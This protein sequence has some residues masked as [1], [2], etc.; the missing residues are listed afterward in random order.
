MDIE[1]TDSELILDRNGTEAKFVISLSDSR[2]IISKTLHHNKLCLK[3]LCGYVTPW[4]GNLDLWYTANKKAVNLLTL[5][6]RCTALCDDAASS[7]MFQTYKT[8]R[9]HFTT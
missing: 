7:K 4:V 1:F 3:H 9:R 2:N 5:T 8:T 6:Y